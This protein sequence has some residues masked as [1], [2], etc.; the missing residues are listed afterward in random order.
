MTVVDFCSGKGC[1]SDM[2]SGRPVEAVAI[3]AELKKGRSRTRAFPIHRAKTRAQ[4]LHNGYHHHFQFGPHQPVTPLLWTKEVVRP[5][6]A[7][8]KSAIKQSRVVSR[9]TRPAM[10]TNNLN[11]HTNG[12]R[13]RCLVT[14]SMGFYS[15]P[16]LREGLC[17][18]GP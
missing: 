18:S 6:A 9:W 15:T 1:F 12:Q 8:A 14:K 17:V 2:G 3:A 16:D 7:L 10:D 11:R 13:A 4:S 5:I